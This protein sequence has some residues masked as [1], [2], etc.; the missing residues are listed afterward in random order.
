MKKL[1]F[2]III[3]FLGLLYANE[4]GVIIDNNVNCR[5]FPSIENSQ[6][7]LKLSSNQKIYVYA[8]LLES[9]IINGKE[10]NWYYI[11]VIGTQINGWVF[12]EFINIESSKDIYTISIQR[13]NRNKY[14]SDL[15]KKVFGGSINDPYST[16]K[17]KAYQL[18]STKE[19][20]F[21][22]MKDSGFKSLNTYATDFGKIKVFVNSETNQ[23]RINSIVIESNS[24]SE[25][26]KINITLDQ[27]SQLI[28]K[29]YQFIEDKIEYPQD[30]FWDSFV[31]EVEIE[32]DKV[33]RI[34]VSK[35]WT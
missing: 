13:L 5:N 32:N 6:V 30:D 17:L 21:W 15:I 9:E 2:V 7:I 16:Q 3:C 34:T 14:G 11:G 4:N 31:Y 28:G 8:K 29:D 33:I 1:Y 27:L 24:I 26:L 10:N 35:Y 18:V 23:F 12:G 25:R 20:S 22:Q 19:T